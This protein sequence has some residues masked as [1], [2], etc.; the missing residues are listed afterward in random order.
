VGTSN[1]RHGNCKPDN[2]KVGAHP[3]RYGQEEAAAGA[4]IDG[5][6][7]AAGVRLTGRRR[8][9][10]VVVRA[11][12][13]VTAAP[14]DQLAASALQTRRAVWAPQAGMLG[15]VMSLL[16]DRLCFSE[17]CRRHEGQPTPSRAAIHPE[18]T[19]I[20][21][22]VRSGRITHDNFIEEQVWTGKQQRCGRAD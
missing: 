7:A 21:Y 6:A 16:V 18:S 17:E 11:A 2:D 12:H 8:R 20:S 19:R 3:G 9:T 5:S 4:S 15:G 13:I 14:A 1:I 22:N 10:S